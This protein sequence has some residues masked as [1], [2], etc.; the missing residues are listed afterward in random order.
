MHSCQRRHSSVAAYTLV[1]ILVVIAIIG[2]LMSLTF[3]MLGAAR[4]RMNQ[5]DC[6]S[7]LRQLA[8]AAQLYES[9]KNRLPGFCESFGVFNGGVDPADP[10][11]FGGNVPKHAKIGSWPVA[12]LSKLDQ[13]PLYERWTMDRYP[14][15]SDGA[16]EYIPTP[17]GYSRLSTANLRIYQCR[18]ATGAVV[19]T[20]KINYIANVGLHV[21][22]F[23]F[24]YTRPSSPMNI[25]SFAR[26]MSRVNGAM[27]NHFAG[28]SPTDRT[29]PVAVGK[30][31]RMESFKDGL[32]NTMLFSES[33][34]AQPWH[35]T[36]LTGNTAHLMDFSMVSGNEVTMYPPES[37]YLQ[38]AVWHF[39][40]DLGFA[41]ASTP[42]PRHKINGG[43]P[44][45]EQMTSTN[46]TDLARPSSLHVT[47][48]NV[49]MADG[50][51][52]FVS[53]TIEYRVY[54]A[55]MTPNGRSS[56]VPHN[57]WLP[58]GL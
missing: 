1:E 10:A 29:Q 30:P 37:R 23:P 5:A 52:Q 16:G 11:N 4:E 45:N 18:S 14:L 36:R 19:D 15:L 50:T 46:Y 31:I 42:A 38:G 2:I 53:E 41:G 6:A 8:I 35:L 17:E 28:W 40:D 26:S 58:T 34:Q 3:P 24:T 39:E 54:Q 43:D 44:Y 48:V 27:T 56:D 20:G 55:M 49:A 32:A 22:R 21:D 7:N 25:V 13:A 51:V 33:N 57:E 9:S 12:L 47:G